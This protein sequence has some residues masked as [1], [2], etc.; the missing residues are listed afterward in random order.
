MLFILILEVVPSGKFLFHL[1]YDLP[2]NS[3][4]FKAEIY[5]R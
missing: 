3:F 5:L 1:S 2:E 4:P